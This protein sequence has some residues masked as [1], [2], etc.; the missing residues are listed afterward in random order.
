MDVDGGSGLVCSLSKGLCS[1]SKEIHDRFFCD[2]LWNPSS[3][4]WTINCAS[5]IP[6]TDTTK[7]WIQF[8][9]SIIL[10]SIIENIFSSS[11]AAIYDSTDKGETVGVLTTCGMHQRKKDL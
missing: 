8:C 7:L 1:P 4:S 3:L 5:W 6:A 10:Q 9:V 2:I 11:G